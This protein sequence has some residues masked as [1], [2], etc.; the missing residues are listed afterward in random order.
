MLLVIGTHMG[1]VKRTINVGHTS[2]FPSFYHK[3]PR[4]TRFV[5]SLA[6]HDDLRQAIKSGLTCQSHMTI[7]LCGS[8]LCQ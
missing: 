3:P 5:A 4:S 8:R 6:R 2:I 1:L 7:A